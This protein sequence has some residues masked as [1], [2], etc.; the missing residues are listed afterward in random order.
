MRQAFFLKVYFLNFQAKRYENTK[1]IR[2]I[3]HQLKHLEK[4]TYDVF[5]KWDYFYNMAETAK[6]GT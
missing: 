5:L 1:R 6:V 2:D 3:S 4:L